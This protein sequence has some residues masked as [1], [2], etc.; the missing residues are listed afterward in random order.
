MLLCYT[1][2]CRGLAPHRPRSC[3]CIHESTYT[4]TCAYKLCVLCRCLGEFVARTVRPVSAQGVCRSI[5]SPPVP[6]GRP[7]GATG[8]RIQMRLCA[9]GGRLGVARAPSKTPQAGR[10]SGPGWRARFKKLAQHRLRQNPKLVP[11]GEP[12]VQ[13]VSDADAARCGRRAWPSTGCRRIR[14]RC[15]WGNPRCNRFQMQTRLGV[16]GGP[17]KTPE[18]GRARFTSWLIRSRCHWGNPR[19]NRLRI[20]ACRALHM[21][22]AVPCEPFTSK[23][24]KA[25]SLATSSIDSTASF[26]SNLY[27]APMKPSFRWS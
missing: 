13:P 8:V 2:L 6:L 15:Q 9:A 22:L 16:A 25:Q 12:Q 14:S 4:G 10:R 17:R 3:T 21:R 7:P 1:I 19:C 27:W 23:R 18:T 5:Y 11:L 26:S 24:M 20:R